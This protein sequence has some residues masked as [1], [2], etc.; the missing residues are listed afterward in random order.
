MR[1]IDTTA[2]EF[3]IV[4]LIYTASGAKQDLGVGDKTGRSAE[5]ARLATQESSVARA[6]SLAHHMLPQRTV[7]GRGAA[8]ETTE[9]RRGSQGSHGRETG[10]QHKT[11]TGFCLFACSKFLTDIDLWGRFLGPYIIGSPCFG[12]NPV[13]MDGKLKITQ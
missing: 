8:P 2:L 5:T 13:I 4:R 1:G 12:I 10:P 3:E 6:A 9:T 11:C 7:L